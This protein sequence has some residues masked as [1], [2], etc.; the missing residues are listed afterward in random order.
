[1]RETDYTYAVARIRANE[2][3][4]L[5][6]ADFD[7]LISA[8]SYDAALRILA[9]KGWNQ[10]ENGSAYDVCELELK[11]TYTFVSESVSDTALF[12]ALAI[13]NDFANL[14]SAIKAFFSDLEPELY[15]T[16][17]YVCE[18][19]II[20]EAVKSGD[21]SSLP[22]WLSDCADEAY[23]AFTEN[24]SGQLAE[25][26]IDKACVKARFAFASEAGCA[27]LEEIN[28]LTA[29]VSDIKIAR[30]SVSTG[31]SREFC[32]NALSGCGLLDAVALTDCAYEGNG[33]AEFV[34]A[35]GLGCLSGYADGD[36][37]S[38][39]M[40]CDN[41]ITRKAAGFKHEIYGADTVVAYYYGKIAE[42][43]N[44]RIILSAKLSGVPKDIISERMREIYV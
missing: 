3:R 38:L 33:L 34:E 44:V 24:Q 10:A 22:G 39:E 2:L 32:L 4:M 12:N 40:Q 17:P 20:I 25:I 8:D 41:L 11:D 27:L 26:I 16:C 36:F 1:M 28:N 5:S 13:G 29:A 14:K 21:F 9:D 7:L 31:K 35:S 37:T 42:I 18:P 30:R 23:H 15:M 43:K 6:K 19:G